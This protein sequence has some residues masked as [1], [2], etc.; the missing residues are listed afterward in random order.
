MAFGGRELRL[1]LS[2]QSYG[3]TNIQRL[4]R[5]ILSLATATEAANRNQLAAQ[6][7]VVREAERAAAS[8]GRISSLQKQAMSAQG[9]APLRARLRLEKQL[10]DMGYRGAVL[11]DL[12]AGKGKA[13]STQAQAMVNTLR[14]QDMQLQK[15]LS[16]L[17]IE[18]VKLKEILAL[19]TRI[20][21]E[22]MAEARARDAMIARQNTLLRQE[23]R[24]RQIAHA[25]RTAQFTGLVGT[26][27]SV[28]V[29]NSFA[30]YNKLVT[31]AATQTRQLG[32]SAE[33]VIRRAD[34]LS[35]GFDNG[36]THIEGILDLMRQFP[37]T[38]DQMA[39]AAFD[40]FSSMT[41][42]FGGG[43][44]LLK[45]FNQLALATGSDLEVATD[46]GITAVNNFDSAGKN[47]G[48]TMG[49]L[50]AIWRFGRMQLSDLNAMF[51]K[52]APAATASGQSLEDVAGAMIAITRLQPSQ[53]VG[54]T[55]IARLLQTFRDPDF[56]RGAFKFGV[57]IT[58][59]A[60]ATGKL[61]PLPDI[62]K[63][64]AQNF[65]LF[66][67]FGGP[68]QLFKEL[69]AVG[70]GRGIGR[71]SRIEAANAFTFLVGHVKEYLFL[72]KSAIE[73]VEEFNAALKAMAQA[74]GTRWAIFTNEM[75]AL[76]LTLG[77]AAIPAML[78]LAGW[79][80]S[81]AHWFENLSSGVRKW[82]GV[83]LVAGSV[84][85]LLVGTF[86]NMAGSILALIA[87]YKLMTGSI[88]L[89]GTEAEIAAAKAGFLHRSLVGLM[90]IGLIA[91]PITLQLLKGGD[92]GMWDFLGAALMGA[93]GG[94]ALGT[95]IG[96][97]GIGTAIGAGV[98]AIA[99][100]I[101]VNLI[102][103]FQDTGKGPGLTKAANEAFKEYTQAWENN[104][105]P[106]HKMARFMKFE[107]FLKAN[108]ALMAAEKAAAKK[109]AKG[110]EGV[111][112]D[113]NKMLAKMNKEM[114]KDQAATTK[115]LEEAW[116]KQDSHL[117]ESQQKQ[118]QL[119]KARAN[120]M[121]EALENQNR[122]IDSA[123][124][125]LGQIY[126]GFRQENE[127][128][129]G[130]F[131]QGPVMQGFLGGIFTGL[132]DLLR[133]F[134]VQIPIPFAIIRKDFDQQMEYFDRWNKDLAELAQR[135]APYTLIES[136]RAMGPETGMA[137]AEGI[138]QA[139]KKGFKQLQADWKK[140]E[141]DIDKITKS[142]L[143][144]QL[145]YWK[146]F[147]TDAA[148]QMV[149]G[150]A[151]SPAWAKLR[152]TFRTHIVQ[153]FGGILQ[154]EFKAEVAAAM[155]QAVQ[156]I[157]AQA[158]GAADRAKAVTPKQ[159]A[160]A[161]AAIAEARRAMLKELHP[162]GVNQ[163]AINVVERQQ[164]RMQKII[165]EYAR[166]HRPG[167]ARMGGLERQMNE[168]QQREAQ[169]RRRRQQIIQDERE[170]IQRQVR[171]FRRTHPPG[172][173]QGQMTIHYHG[174]TVTIQAGATVA[175]I[176]RALNRASFKKRNKA[177]RT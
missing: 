110:T 85:A 31:L 7:Q 89:V 162:A 94:A 36:G 56:Q 64:M 123:L 142:Q 168:L 176:V 68:S 43:L 119:A 25:G 20:N 63:G 93:A 177:Q 34:E 126:D 10:S 116:R 76:V 33:V 125:N 152:P 81:A 111:K 163:A 133:Q 45:S 166:T 139:P 79:I 86:V 98:G 59:G 83:G 30:N 72:Q 32:E 70:R 164:A 146:T 153:A 97:P 90:G 141:K 151:T 154:A 11:Q 149:N 120:A 80:E 170:A 75:R 131:G 172:T 82:V 145:K 150:L 54:A 122:K 35:N 65:G 14:A 128:A 132:N 121:Q 157:A 159:A 117:S 48:K 130:G 62:I 57:D 50:T 5:D 8:Q 22:V 92:P 169:L 1:I 155:E 23:A 105:G 140:R 21:T 39:Q 101:T 175:E 44:K 118:V 12:L 4:R 174:D 2:I 77:E 136:I 51:E 160:N 42:S 161:K 156:D 17:G 109:H 58:K 19:Q 60:E 49:L 112:S 143:D 53:R 107:D 167:T 71:Q 27:I 66:E 129:F 46:L 40:I 144:S 15:I 38:G 24:G 3:T 78:K 115:K 108:P 158:P 74:P 84:S 137:I 135:G 124:D 41:V 148:W 28:G 138:L 127:R 100:P 6:S 104:F 88:R 55:G 113:Y 26:A 173:P 171:Q 95:A 103:K 114:L 134:G 165:R 96:G 99:L 67:K 106:G 61:K 91:I 9:I 52:V 16:D 87:N 13:R 73:D 102:S 147:G 37:A 69:T 18:E 47:L 29:T